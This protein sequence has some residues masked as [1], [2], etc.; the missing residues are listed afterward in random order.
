MGNQVDNLWNKTV[1][2]ALVVVVVAVDIGTS[3]A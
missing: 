1:D 3:E 2:T